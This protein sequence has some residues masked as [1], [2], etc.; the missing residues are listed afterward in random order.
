MKLVK[1]QK[2]IDDAI[3]RGIEDRKHTIEFPRAQ[4]ALHKMAARIYEAC[5]GNGYAVLMTL[6]SADLG[7]CLPYQEHAHKHLFKDGKAFYRICKKLGLN[8]VVGIDSAGVYH[9]VVSLRHYTS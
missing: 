3:R 9:I 6:T 5:C 2:E 8:P 4:E 7:D 1:L